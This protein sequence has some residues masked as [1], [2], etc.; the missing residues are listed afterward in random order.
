M[1]PECTLKVSSPAELIAAVPYL[2]GFHPADSVTVVAFRGPRVRF[3][4]RHDLPGPDQPADE[5]R[6]DADHVAEVVARQGVDGATVIGYGPAARVTPAVT[7]TAE[8]LRRQGLV[9]HDELRVTDGRYWSYRCAEP[10]CCPPEGLPC[11]PQ[12]SAVAA[13][14]TYAGQVALPDRAALVDQVGSVA[15]AE[16]VAM[17]AATARAQGRLADLMA[18][19]LHDAGFARLVRHSG[20]TA[21]RAAERCYRSGRRPGDD[22]VAWLGVLLIHLPVRDYAWERIGTE[23]WRVAMWTDVLRRVEPQYLLAPACLLGFAAWRAGMGALARVAV[24]RALL[25]DPRYPMARLLEDVLDYALDP[26]AVRG[27]PRVT[28]PDDPGGDPRKVRA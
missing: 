8:A 9:V 19:D 1:T 5:L 23:P 4:A 28:D 11:P 7:R 6:A 20:R 14:A 24:D 25:R 18:R 27:W 16:R 13:A 15:G 26:A 10:E 12:N 21:V 22:D 17:T 3:A 2:L